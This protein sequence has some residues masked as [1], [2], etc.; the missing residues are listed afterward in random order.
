MYSF[1]K[2]K[3]KWV[4]HIVAFFNQD[5]K[6]VIFL[7]SWIEE[8]ALVV[9]LERWTSFM[10]IFLRDFPKFLVFIYRYVYKMFICSYHILVIF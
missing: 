1:T 2:K 6:S 4:K 8:S 7:H 5:T 9:K 10:Q 3:K